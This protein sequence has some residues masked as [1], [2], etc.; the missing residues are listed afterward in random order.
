MQA[1]GDPGG[2][3]CFPGVA[4]AGSVDG[5]ALGRREVAGVSQVY[6][7]LSWCGLVVS[8]GVLGVVLG[9]MLEGLLVAFVKDARGGGS[10]WRTW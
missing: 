4:G 9:M 10:P 6:A 3:G 1:A 2:R 8:G 5:S 7:V